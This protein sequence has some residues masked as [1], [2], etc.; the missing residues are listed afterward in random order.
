MLYLIGLGLNEKGFSKEA[1]EAVKLAKKVYLENYTVELP[2]SVKELEKEMEVEIHSVDRSFVEDTKNILHE[3]S[4]KDTALLVYGNPLMATTHIILLEDAINADVKTKIIHAASIFDA[5][6]ESGLQMYKFGKTASIPEFSADS[7]IEIIKENN[8]IKAHTLILI[9]IGMNFKEALKR[10]EKDCK[11]N[12]FPLKE[13]VVCSRLGTNDKKIV[14][15][16]IEDLENLSVKPPFCFIIP[17]ELHFVE[18]SVL[19]RI[20]I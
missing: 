12:K 7:Y 20:G 3:A 9:D 4:K 18:E 19:E 10:L 13:I 6:S 16:S 17:G 8:K 5:V 14:F 11:E 2:Y 1:L 15:G